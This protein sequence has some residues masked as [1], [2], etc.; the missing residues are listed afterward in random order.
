MSSVTLIFLTHPTQKTD[1]DITPP[2]ST[3]LLSNTIMSVEDKLA[4]PEYEGYIIYNEPVEKTKRS[5]KYF[6][7]LHNTAVKKGF[8]LITLENEGVSGALN[9]VVPSITTDYILFVEH[10]WIFTDHIDISHLTS[11]MNKNNHINLIRFPSFEISGSG[12][13][14]IKNTVQE[15]YKGVQLTR[16]NAYSNHPHLVRTDVYNRWLRNMK[17]SFKNILKSVKDKEIIKRYLK[18]K[19]VKDPSRN[20][21][22]HIFQSILTSQLNQYGFDYVSKRYGLYIYGGIGDGP[23]IRHCGGK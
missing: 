19:I 15:E 12:S 9:A 5:R 6:E 1:D 8:A 4:L 18:Y 21:A 3:E 17:L 11:I 23:Y 22:E 20:S 16:N 14:W 7:N 10:D 2:P 13:S